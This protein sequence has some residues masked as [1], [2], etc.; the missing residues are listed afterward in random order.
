MR[1][2]VL[3]EDDLP[4]AGPGVAAGVQLL[5]PLMCTGKDSHMFDRY[6]AVQL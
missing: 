1:C 4:Q 6:T 5:R 2:H 3:G